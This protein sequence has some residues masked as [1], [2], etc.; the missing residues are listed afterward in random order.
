VPSLL[1]LDAGHGAICDSLVGLSIQGYPNGKAAMRATSDDLNATDGLAARPLPYCLKAIFAK[2]PVAQSDRF[3]FHHLENNY[4]KKVTSR[5]VRGNPTIGRLQWPYAWV[6]NRASPEQR[7]GP[8]AGADRAA[9][10]I[11][12][13]PTPVLLHAASWYKQ[14]QAVTTEYQPFLAHGN[15]AWRRAWKP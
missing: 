11:P 8:C 12:S 3:E 5:D 13:E 2:R 15:A 7:G 4:G 1:A 14:N 9:S 6:E 10:A